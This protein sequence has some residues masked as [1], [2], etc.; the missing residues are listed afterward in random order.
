MC[1]A[2]TL[3]I[4]LLLLL[5]YECECSGEDEGED[6]SASAGA[7]GGQLDIGQDVVSQHK[8]SSFFGE[9]NKVKLG[10]TDSIHR[11]WPV[12]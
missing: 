11:G 1:R 6:A 4:L 8:P 10:T 7:S 9:N 5:E 12:S 3:L 2:R